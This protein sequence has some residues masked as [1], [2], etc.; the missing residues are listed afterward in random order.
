M[1]INNFQ[2]N[3]PPKDGTFF[4][5]LVK[6]SRDSGCHLED[7]EVFWTIGFND[8]DDNGDNDT[9]RCVGWSWCHD[10]IVETTLTVEEIIGWLPMPTIPDKFLD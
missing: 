1:S 4:L 7:S 2:E 3:S 8:F 5:L 10:E 6:P 9:W